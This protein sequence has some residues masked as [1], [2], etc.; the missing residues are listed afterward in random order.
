MET[1][2][3]KS[4]PFVLNLSAILIQE[5]KKS[6]TSYTAYKWKQPGKAAS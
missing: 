6:L 1:Y 4:H 2:M 5:P 3:H